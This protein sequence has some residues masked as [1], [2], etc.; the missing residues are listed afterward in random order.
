MEKDDATWLNVAYIAFAGTMAYVFWEAI[1]MA[2]VQFNWV[3]RYEWW[4]IAQNGAAVALGI[5]SAY[6]LKAKQERHEYFLASINEL[7]KVTWPTIP[8]TRKMTWIVSWVVG[9]FAV[10]LAAFDWAWGKIL[11]FIL[12]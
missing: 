10:V 8:D 11:A 1:N 6:V 12:A 2:G 7:R 5:A 9:F 3:E 4:A